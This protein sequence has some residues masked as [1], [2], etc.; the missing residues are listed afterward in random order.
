MYSQ[1]IAFL[2]A[3]SSVSATR[4]VNFRLMSYRSGT[5]AHLKKVVFENGKLYLGGSG[6]SIELYVDAKR[7]REQDTGANFGANDDNQLQLAHAQTVVGFA[8]RSN[9]LKLNDTDLYACPRDGR[10][11]LSISCE[12]GYTISLKVFQEVPVGPGYIL[13]GHDIDMEEKPRTKSTQVPS[14]T[15]IADSAGPL[16][17]TEEAEKS[18]TTYYPKWG[19]GLKRP[20]TDDGFSAGKTSEENGE[21]HFWRLNQT[22]KVK[23]EQYTPVFDGSDFLLARRWLT[24]IL[25]KRN[26]KSNTSPASRVALSENKMF[27]D[28]AREAPAFGLPVKRG[29]LP[30]NL[31]M[32]PPSDGDRILASLDTPT[33]SNSSQ[34]TVGIQEQETSNTLRV[35]HDAIF[36]IQTNTELKKGSIVGPSS[37]DSLLSEVNSESVTTMELSQQSTVTPAIDTTTSMV[38]IAPGVF[39]PTTYTVS[40]LDQT[41]RKRILVGWWISHIKSKFLGVACRTSEEPTSCATNNVPETSNVIITSTVVT[42][43]TATTTSTAVTT[44]TTITTSTVTSSRSIPPS[45]STI[46]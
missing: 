41:L 38:L 5:E 36:Y 15:D 27:E 12:N 3:V 25:L 44:S 34:R 24:S 16:L 32:Q 9:H 42:T 18:L 20:R 40:P 46:P 8:V 35:S 10:L 6:S 30:Q 11:Q 2:L 13:E 4:S 1:L 39:S 37:S 33:K 28:D 45:V 7:L 29:V 17:S 19:G 23:V 22:E 26:F 14:T 31:P 43:S 21:N